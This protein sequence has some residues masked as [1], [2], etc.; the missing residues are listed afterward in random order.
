MST[1][2][3]FRMVITPRAPRLRRARIERRTRARIHNLDTTYA[4]LNLS[5]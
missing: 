5:P 1:S 3:L 4:W 2:G